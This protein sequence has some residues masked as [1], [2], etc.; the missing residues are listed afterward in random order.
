MKKALKSKF[1]KYGLGGAINYGLK[2]GLTFLFTEVL[3]LYYLLSY[4][5]TLIVV[6]LYSFLYNMFITYNKTADKLRTFVKYIIALVVFGAVDF[7]FV[8]LIT[9]QNGEA[10]YML[11]IIIVTTFVFVTK[12]FVFNKFV[13]NK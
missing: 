12:Y 5:I 6:I 1:F 11:S 13:F 4:A 10:Y 7:F 9:D 3:T 8:K 2:I